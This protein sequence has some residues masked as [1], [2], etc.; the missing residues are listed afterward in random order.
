MAYGNEITFRFV[1]CHVCVLL[2]MFRRCGMLAVAYHQSTHFNNKSSTK[3]NLCKA[4]T[5]N[6]TKTVQRFSLHATYI[7]VFFPLLPLSL[8][9]ID[10][11]LKQTLD[12][13][14]MF[15]NHKYIFVSKV[16]KGVAQNL[17]NRI[18]K[19]VIE[20]C[21]VFRIDG[22]ACM[23]SLH[24]LLT[25]YFSFFLFDHAVFTKKYLRIYIFINN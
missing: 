19:Y 4:H 10:L 15:L 12:I 8:D 5:A 14:H 9:V 23:Y 24:Y 13:I 1:V 7:F 2:W 11:A 22:S 21:D 17:P 18:Y 6:G 3:I 20:Y 25:Y 16:I